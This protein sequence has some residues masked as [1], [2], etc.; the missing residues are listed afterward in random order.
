MPS[1]TITRTNLTTV[2][3]AACHLNGDEVKSLVNR[4]IELIAEAIVRDQRVKLSSFGTFEVRSR[5]ARMGRNP[6]TLEPALIEP[7]SVVVFVPSI[8]LRT[9]VQNV[10]GS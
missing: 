3:Y 1:K 9:K 2:A 6:S 10:R 5:K 8:G 4:T 7:R